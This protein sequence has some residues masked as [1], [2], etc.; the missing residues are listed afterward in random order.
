M[1]CVISRHAAGKVLRHQSPL[2]S[3]VHSLLKHKPEYVL[4]ATMKMASLPVHGY[5]RINGQL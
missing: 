5:N 3:Q 1:L 4:N 2:Y